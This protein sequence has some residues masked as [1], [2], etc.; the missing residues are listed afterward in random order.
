MVTLDTGGYQ[1]DLHSSAVLRQVIQ[2]LPDYQ[3]RAWVRQT[4]GMHPHLPSLR[5]LDYFLERVVEEETAVPA[6]KPV[7]EKKD[8]KGHTD[9]KVNR[10]PPERNPRN[11]RDPTGVPPG[12]N[13]RRA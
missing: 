11:H 13:P 6:V 5:D 3:R 10:D 12:P 9:G 7:K 1:H 8:T 4:F 2:A